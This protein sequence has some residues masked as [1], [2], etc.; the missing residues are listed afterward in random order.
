MKILKKILEFIHNQIISLEKN[1]LV[2][3]KKNVDIL[4]L[5][6]KL[7]LTSINNYF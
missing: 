3:K 2:N 7:F 1:V 6:Y 4:L 5:V